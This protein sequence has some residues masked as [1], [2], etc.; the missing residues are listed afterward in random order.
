[1]KNHLSWL[2]LFSF[3]GLMSA[4]CGQ[5]KAPVATSGDEVSRYLDE[6]PEL[7]EKQADP[8]LSDPTK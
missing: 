2:L 7:K 5:T 6:H 4:G 1:M 3:C 8:G